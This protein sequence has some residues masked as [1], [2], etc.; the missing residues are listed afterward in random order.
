MEY[1][2]QDVRKS[3]EISLSKSAQKSD[4]VLD[5]DIFSVLFDKDIRRVYI[6]KKADRLVKALHM[7]RPGFSYSVAIRDKID[8]IAVGI[9]DAAVLPPQSSRDTLA[10]HLLALSSILDAAC[11][12]GTLSPMNAGILMREA[13]ALLG[14]VC[15]YEEPGIALSRVPTIADL[16][17]ATMRRPA[18]GLRKNAE[19]RDGQPFA[20]KRTH[21]GHIK[22][23][24]NIRSSMILSI[25]KDKNQAYIKDISTLMRDVSEKTIQRDLQALVRSGHVIAQGKKRWTTYALKAPETQEIT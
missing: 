25:L 5:K 22:D 17:R 8:A 19:F 13:H 16:D 21:K 15:E 24:I 11:E 6:Y 3:R 23:E 2:G 10:R 12:S 1:K 18:K 14:E 4:L 9:I 7:I 20:Q